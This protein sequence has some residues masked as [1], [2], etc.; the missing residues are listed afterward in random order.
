MGRAS[1]TMVSQRSRTAAGAPRASGTTLAVLWD[2]RTG[3]PGGADE[4][5]GGDA[6]AGFLKA[7]GDADISVLAEPVAAASVTAEFLERW[8]APADAAS[9]EWEE[10][11]GEHV[12]GPLAEAALATALKQA[13]VTGGARASMI[14]AGP[15]GRANKRAVS[16]A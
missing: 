7:S 16:A 3:L 5:N 15:Y 10:R 4:R 12:Y 13:G 11:F 1:A 8:R 14:V 9:R 2:I 6:A